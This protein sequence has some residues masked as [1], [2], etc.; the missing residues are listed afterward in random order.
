MN[1]NRLITTFGFRNCAKIHTLMLR[2][3]FLRRIE[4]LEGLI[5]LKYLDISHNQMNEVSSIR[6]LSINTNLQILYLEGNPLPPYRQHCYT[7][8]LSLSLL[9][10]SPTPPSNSNK[11]N[12]IRNSYSL[13]RKPSCKPKAAQPLSHRCKSA[14]S[15]RN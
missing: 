15:N 4:G 3:N 12:S 6:P 9:D 14:M 2:G 7:M 5:D 1:H 13:R 8:L 10:G 11:L